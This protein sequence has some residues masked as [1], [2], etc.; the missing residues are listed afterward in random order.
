MVAECLRMDGRS[1]LRGIAFN[2]G[3]CLAV[4]LT[5]VSTAIRGRNSIVIFPEVSITLASDEWLRHVFAVVGR[6]ERSYASQAVSKRRT[7]YYVDSPVLLCRLSDLRLFGP[8]SPQ[9]LVW[10]THGVPFQCSEEKMMK[11]MKFAWLLPLAFAVL[12]LPAVDGPVRPQV[13]TTPAM[14]GPVRPQVAARLTVDGPVRPQVAAR[15]TVDG[16]V[17]P[18]VVAGL[19]ADGP[20]RPQV[21]AGLAL[22]GPVRPQATTAPAVDGPVR[23]QV[24]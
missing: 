9:Q 16:P 21:T 19:T 11:T 2:H 17:R 5:I 10:S 7:I 22:D 6:Q 8:P 15:L 24:A 18:Q 1:F 13:A 12:V 3:H 23:P 20:V 4:R 14:D